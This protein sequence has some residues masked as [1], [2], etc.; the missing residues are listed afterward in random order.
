MTI[1]ERMMAVYRGQMPDRPPLGVYV[2]YLPRGEVDRA[3]RNLGMGLIDYV[4]LTTQ[5]GPPWHMLPGFLSEIEG[6]SLTVRHYWKD[7]L[8][9]EVRTYDTPV[10]SVSADVGQDVGAG[11]EHIASYYLKSPEDYRTMRWIVERA[12]LAPNAAL[13]RG[14]VERMGEDGVVMGRMDRT[15]YQKLLLELAGGEQFLMDLYDDPEPV[16]ELL[17]ALGRRF[18]GQVDRAMDSDAELI[19]LPDNVTVDMTPPPACEKYLLPHYEYCAQCARQA[20]KRVVAHYDGRIR[21]LLPFLKRTGVDVLESV[22]APSIGGD[23]PFREALAALPDM[24]ILPNFPSNLCGAP[25]D[26]IAACVRD[27]LAAAAGRPFMLQI[28]E[29]LAE[30]TWRRVIPLVTRAMFE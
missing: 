9:R 20:G 27:Y 30:G 15:P 26:V 8:M 12:R 10:G 1:R 17:D 5:I 4:P 24:V 28:S 21:P 3:V 25:D 7:G 6:A 11:S 13:Y 19:W 18:H 2:R 23:M 29:D 14:A 16:E 22:S